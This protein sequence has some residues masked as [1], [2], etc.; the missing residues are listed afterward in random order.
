MSKVTNIFLRRVTG[1][2]TNVWLSIGIAVVLA[3]FWLCVNL[4]RPLQEFSLEYV[5]IPLAGWVTNGLFFWLLILLWSAYREW[6]RTISREEKVE[7]ILSSIESEVV[8]VID[9][10]RTIRDCSRSVENIFGYTVGEVVGSTTDRLYEDRRSGGRH[11][12]RE[13]LHAVGFHVG[14]ATG[15]RKDG[16][17]L[18]LEIVTSPLRGRPGALILIRDIT[19]RE[20]ARRKILEAKESAEEANRRKGELLAELEANYR[21]LQELENMRDSL[22]HMIVHDLK[23]P[24]SAIRM[25][26]AMIERYAKTG[27]REREMH[28]VNDAAR[29]VKR[30]ALMISS[31]LDMSRLQQNKMPLKIGM[32]DLLPLAHDAVALVRPD[33]DGKGV[34]VLLP[35]RSVQ[36]AC[37]PEVVSRVITNLVGNAIKYTPSGGRV[38]LQFEEQE[39]DTRVAVMDSGSGIPPDMQEKIFERYGQVEAMEFSTG[40]GLTFCKLAVEAQ[41]GRI[42]VDSDV[43]RGSTFWFRLPRRPPVG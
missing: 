23:S 39:G 20:Q 18:P 43:G 17:R 38:T 15:I 21:K 36:A 28:Y 26:L 27:D 6:S 42:G 40:L 31:L 12:V 29:L 41:G 35:D 11:D 22:T 7:Q 2:R 25:Q 3:A 9:P 30:M 32:Y 19:E 37:D 5:R 24:L 14:K 8:A 34:S 13:S 1:A 10:D 33:A 4:S 16:S